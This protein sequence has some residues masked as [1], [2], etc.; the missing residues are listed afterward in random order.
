MNSYFLI[1]IDDFNRICWVYFLKHKDEVFR[2]FK[3]FKELFDNKS[4]H[5]IKSV[6][7]RGGEYAYN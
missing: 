1:F 4:D 6:S 2:C 7:D 5:S 3:K